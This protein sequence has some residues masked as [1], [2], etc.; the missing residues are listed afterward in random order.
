MGDS[1]DVVLSNYLH[2]DQRPDSLPQSVLDIKPAVHRPASEDGI[3]GDFYSELGDGLL[4]RTGSSTNYAG[5]FNGN[6][7]AYGVFQ[8]SDK[9]LK[10]NVQEFEDAMSLINKLKPRNY[11]FKSDEKLAALHLPK[12]LHYG[13]M[14]Q[15]VEEV[16]PNL[17]K[18]VN[19]NLN[20]P[21][22]EDFSVQKSQPG[23]T[24]TGEQPV[25]K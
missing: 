16:L 3:G 6:V 21:K 8:S 15:D 20:P 10:Q 7:Y 5:V 17:V 11:E 23:K 18:E 25:M 2:N 12:G 24:A 4:T 22:S 13:L 19:Q 9:N 1:V 14:A